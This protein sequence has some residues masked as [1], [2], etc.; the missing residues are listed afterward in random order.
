MN[1]NICAKIMRY[2]HS[3]K[4][5]CFI[6]TL[7]HRNSL[8]IYILFC[9]QHARCRI[10]KYEANYP[11]TSL[12]LLQRSYLLLR[13]NY[14]YSQKRIHRGRLAIQIWNKISISPVRNSNILQIY[15]RHLFARSTYRIIRITNFPSA[16]VI[17]KNETKKIDNLKCNSCKVISQSH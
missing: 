3:Q 16:T 15:Y 4:W 12:L 17:E 14:C 1:E 5:H 8:L 7:A 9:I 6:V 2:A 10:G 13:W 11:E